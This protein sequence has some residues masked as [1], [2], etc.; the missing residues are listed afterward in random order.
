[1][2]GPPRTFMG[3]N[4]MAKTTKKGEEI[5][6]EIDALSAEKEIEG[7][8]KAAFDLLTELLHQQW[9]RE[10]TEAKQIAL[11]KSFIPEI[12]QK[13]ADGM[14]LVGDIK[15]LRFFE[16]GSEVVYSL[17]ENKRGQFLLRVFYNPH[18]A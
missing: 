5:Q 11:E 8:S 18:G 13:Y 4:E 17:D 1:M 3:E 6:A 9:L 14:I 15:D 7:L 16:E 2:R 10:F 12:K